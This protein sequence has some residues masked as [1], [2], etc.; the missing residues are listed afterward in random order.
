[1]DPATVGPSP[2]AELMVPTVTRYTVAC[3]KSSLARD[4]RSLAY[5]TPRYAQVHGLPAV[6]ERRP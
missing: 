6:L 5:L 1:M 4:R 3:F 2:S